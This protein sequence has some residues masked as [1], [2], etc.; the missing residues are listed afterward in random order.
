MIIIH[1]FY[2]FRRICKYFKE[3]HEN[4]EYVDKCRRPDC[5]PS[6]HSWSEC[7]PKHCPYMNKK[8]PRLISYYRTEVK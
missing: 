1:S 2:D 8:D 7:D 5:I 3:G 4:G 6:G